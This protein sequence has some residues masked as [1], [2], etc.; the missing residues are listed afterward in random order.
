MSVRILMTSRLLSQAVR[1][2]QQSAKSLI[3]RTYCSEYDRNTMSYRDRMFDNSGRSDRKGFGGGGGRMG[4]GL[5]TS[6]GRSDRGGGY[7]RRGGG[8]GGGG[9]GGPRSMKGSQP[10]EKLRKPRWDLNRL[11]K[12][13]KSFYVE[14]PS[15]AA[16]TQ[17]EV[18]AFHRENQIT[19]K[20]E[21]IPKPLFS[22]SEAGF[23]EYVLRQVRHNNWQNP[24][25]IQAQGWPIAL[26]GLDMVAI[27]Q[28]GSGKTLGFIL[29]SLVHISAQ[30]Y[31]SPGDGP[32]CL[33]LVP[34]RELAQQV[35]VVAQEFGQLS[36]IR[37][38]C[39][40]G[41]AP[42]GP[43]IRSLERGA[44]I[45]IA[46]PGRLIDFL[47]TEKT[48]LRRTTYLVLDEA[49]RMLDMGFEPQIRKILEQ[50]RPDR[51]TLMWSATWPKEVRKLAED[52]LQDYVQANIG[53]LQLTAN[54]NILQIIDVCQEYEKE[55]KLMKLLDEIMQERENKT[56]IFV[57]TK[58][59]C[60]DISR[61]MKREGWPV[62]AIHGD[63]SQQE[64]DWVLSEFR[65]GKT[66]M[67]I[68]TDVASRGLD[69]DDIKFVI[70]FDYPNCSEDYVHRI[71]RTARSNNTG[72]AYTFFT[73]G[74]GKQVNDL[75]GVLREA[76]QTINPKLIQLAESSRHMM[77]KG[78][79]R[80][81]DRKVGGRDSG[82]RF[83]GFGGGSSRGGGGSRGGYGSSGGSSRGGG[84][85]SSSGGGSSYSSG[86]GSRFSSQSQSSSRGGS[87]GGGASRG[88][89]SYS[90][91]QGSYG[92]RNQ[93]SY[94]S[95]GQQAQ[96]Q[97]GYQG[98]Q[99]SYQQ[100]NGSQYGSQ[101]QSSGT[102][103]NN[104]AYMYSQWMSQTQPASTAASTTA[105]AAPP[106]PPSSAAPPPPPPPGY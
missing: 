101:Q 83:G 11:P 97:Q 39:V 88:S 37:N 28:T 6:F 77:G 65:T 45:C 12:F 36:K 89:N 100:S 29:P 40:Y 90:N 74:N 1:H 4:N 2:C 98:Y 63:K 30:P 76:N 32:I 51:Q 94:S 60:D 86:G 33:V 67:M 42:K 46:T 68:A 92:N 62:M 38:C 23:P 5:P 104:M 75:I 15:V 20:G 99:Q 24:T 31:L 66:P 14:A 91:N 55:Q 50:V 3:R 59:K 49:D 106:L 102:D 93:N 35:Q 71:G 73:P 81:G 9:M 44:E 56:I 54:H 22:F 34:T 19:L 103:L 85:Y 61:K 58:R 8:R 80:W 78:R 96:Q 13:E 64:R 7:D 48:N 57:E 52:F 72:T 21:N 27:A 53:A 47:E 79:S 16:R 84:S 82:S 25:P 43:Q 26:S 17:A 10:G 69:V 70:N 18:D 87:R 105:A 95:G 41:G